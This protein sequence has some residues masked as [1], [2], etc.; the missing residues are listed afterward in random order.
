MYRDVKDLQEEVLKLKLSDVDPTKPPAPKLK[1]PNMDALPGDAPSWLRQKI[2]HQRL[3]HYQ[4]KDLHE[5]R[6]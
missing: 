6:D 4:W 3:G 2:Q 5:D 1:Y